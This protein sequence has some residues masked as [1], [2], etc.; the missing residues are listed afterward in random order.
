MVFEWSLKVRQVLNWYQVDP[1]SLN[2]I[3]CIDFALEIVEQSI[4]VLVD[5]TASKRTF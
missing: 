2:A 3:N 1:L 4:D 5:T